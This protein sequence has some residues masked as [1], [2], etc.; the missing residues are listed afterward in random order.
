MYPYIFLPSDTAYGK[1]KIDGNW[2]YFD[3]SNVSPSSEDAV[4]VKRKYIECRCVALIVM[5]R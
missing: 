2:Y 1:N 3:D 4:V 5:N